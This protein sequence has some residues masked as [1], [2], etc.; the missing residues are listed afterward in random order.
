MWVNEDYEFTIDQPV[1]YFE[2]I[3]NIYEW[4]IYFPEPITEEVWESDLRKLR[5][6]LSEMVID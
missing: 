3:K 6:F 5:I 2:D 4:E 1:N